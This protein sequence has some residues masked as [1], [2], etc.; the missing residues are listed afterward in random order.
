MSLLQYE[1]RTDLLQKM[2]VTGINSNNLV[3]LQKEAPWSAKSS[4]IFP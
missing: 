1:E 3:Y 4:S 2:S